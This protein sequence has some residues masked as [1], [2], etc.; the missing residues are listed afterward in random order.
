MTHTGG[1]GID[2]ADG[3]Q[4]STITGNFIHDTSGG[5]VS[6]GE[7]DDR[8]P[9]YSDAVGIWAGC[10]RPCSDAMRKDLELSGTAGRSSGSKVLAGPWW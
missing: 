8:R 6:V 7:V 5:G 2:L 1:T 4:N 3:T 10:T 9:D